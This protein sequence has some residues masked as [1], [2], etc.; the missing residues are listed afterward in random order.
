MNISTIQNVILKAVTCVVPEK[1][2]D[3]YEFAKEHFSEDLSKTIKAVG[4]LKRHVCRNRNNTALTLGVESAK[5]LFTELNYDISNIGALVFVTLTPDSLMPNNASAAHHILGLHGNCPAFD[6]NH[7]CSGYTYGLWIAS[8][9]CS[10]LKKDVLLID[11]DTNSFYVSDKDKATGLLFGDA[12]SASLLSYNEKAE[13]INFCFFTDAEKRDALTMPGFGFKNPLNKDSLIYKTYEDGSIRRD[14]D[15]YMDGENV[16]NYVVNN[17]PKHVRKF[18]DEIEM[19]PEEYNCLVL[20]QANAFMLRRLA[21]KIGFDLDKIPFS[22]H[23]Y[24]NTSSVSIPLTICS[25]NINFNFS[26]L[27]LLIGMGAGLST[28]IVSIKLDNLV[29]ASVISKDL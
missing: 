11:S 18:L 8:L 17:V 27:N 3:N 21:K 10:N 14:I 20:H 6:I 1:T 9:M 5:K 15:M 23:E 26:G 16:F 4:V 25:Q 19:E 29:H 12:G 7:A 2:I 24:G 13:Q 28:G 22:I